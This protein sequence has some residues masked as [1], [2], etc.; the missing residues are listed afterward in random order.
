MPLYSYKA[1]NKNGEVVYGYVDGRDT[2]GV[3]NELRQNGLILIKITNCTLNKLNNNAINLQDFFCQ[4]SI[5]LAQKITL[6]DAL[7]IISTTTN[8]RSTKRILTE[9]LVNI[10]NGASFADALV[11][12]PRIFKPFVVNAIK[13]AEKSSNVKKIC[14]MLHKN[15]ETSALLK[16]QQQKAI[17]YP[18]CVLLIV[19]LFFIITLR[20]IIPNIKTFFNGT[21]NQRLLFSLSDL[22][23]NHQY[24]SIL[25][26]FTFC[27][28]LFFLWKRFTLVST[29]H[30][31]H[32]SLMWLHTLACL[33]QSGIAVREALVLSKEQIK[34]PSLKKT[35]DSIIE[36][37]INGATFHNALKNVNF[38][39]TSAAKFAEIGESCGL[40]GDLIWYGSKFEMQKFTEKIQQRI[41]LIQP[42]LLTLFGL[43]LLWVILAIFAPLYD[44]LSGT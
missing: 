28:G 10:T 19:S 7:S 30:V 3:A 12:Y 31:N 25:L 39:P 2:D 9:I 26:L 33:L 4:L 6:K 23:V 1:T 44:N 43:F 24:V 16:K 35:I 11:H 15:F 34:S 29:N 21:T 17:I 40:L 18:L 36:K 37:V 22:S 42:I 32:S 20:T 5:L 14:S 13:S 27:T 38:I 8:V 41:S